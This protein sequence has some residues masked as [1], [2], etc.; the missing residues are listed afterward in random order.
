MSVSNYK[1]GLSTTRGATKALIDRRRR[2]LQNPGEDELFKLILIENQ[3]EKE[4]SP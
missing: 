2:A 3:K 1:H 4:V